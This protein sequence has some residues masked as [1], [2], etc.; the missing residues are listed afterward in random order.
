MN[1]MV[2]SDLSPTPKGNDP[3]RDVSSWF[4]CSSKAELL[5]PSTAIISINIVVELSWD[6]A[7]GS[8]DHISM[9]RQLLNEGV[10][11]SGKELHIQAHVQHQQIQP[12]SYIAT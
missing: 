9:S 11:I 6:Q 12:T 1:K 3:G 8:K 5:T 4:W 10:S 2:I 7:T